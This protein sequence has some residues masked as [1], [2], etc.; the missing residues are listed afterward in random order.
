LINLSVDTKKVSKDEEGDDP[1]ILYVVQFDLEERPLIKIGVTT[2][3]IEDR[4]SEILVSIF[5]QYREFP[6]CRPKRFTRTFD[7]YSKEARMHEFFKDYSY[8]PKKRFS[9]CTEF[10][11]VPL[12]DVAVA[13]DALLVRDKLMNL[14]S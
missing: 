3:Q 5:K 1:G 7:I 9:G 2:R 11:D 12:E 6:Y 8:L 10:F 13:Y 14:C 4:I